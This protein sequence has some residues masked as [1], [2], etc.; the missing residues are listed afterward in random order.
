MTSQVQAVQFRLGLAGALGMARRAA[1]FA[2]AVTILEKGTP[3]I[4]L[5]QA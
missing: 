1:L 2:V 4:S 3:Q 5:Q